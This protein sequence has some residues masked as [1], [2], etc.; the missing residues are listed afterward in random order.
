MTADAIRREGVIYLLLLHAGRSTRRRGRIIVPSDLV[1]LCTSNAYIE[2]CTPGD[3][4]SGRPDALYM[5]TVQ[6]MVKCWSIEVQWSV[7]APERCPNDHAVAMRMPAAGIL[8]LL[9]RSLYIL[10]GACLPG[11][12]MEGLFLFSAT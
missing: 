3:L 4:P 8:Y 6:V 12:W 9:L 1:H 5:A 11:R 2:N 10:I 7:E